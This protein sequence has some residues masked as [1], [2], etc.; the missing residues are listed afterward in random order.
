MKT[1]NIDLGG[2]FELRSRGRK[3][4][5]RARVNRTG[6]VNV[7]L[8][9]HLAGD[10]RDRERRR[11]AQT[12]EVACDGWPGIDRFRGD[13]R[14]EGSSDVTRGARHLKGAKAAG[15]V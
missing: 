3:D 1:G 6:R 14:R 15:R 12:V 5:K 7:I 11:R 4:V 10:A 8:E 13:T 2:G 9:E